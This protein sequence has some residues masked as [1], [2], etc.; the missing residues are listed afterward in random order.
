M[1]TELGTILRNLRGKIPLREAAMKI[2]ISHTYLRSLEKGEKDKPSLE[3]IKSLAKA[4]DYSE[5]E[6]MIKAG[7]LMSDLDAAVYNIIFAIQDVL[8]ESVEKNRYLQ[9]EID[10]F[11]KQ[12]IESLKNPTITVN[13]LKG[14][15]YDKE[16]DDELV[17]RLGDWEQ[18]EKIER[19]LN[20]LQK[21]KSDNFEIDIRKI[22][23]NALKEITTY[24]NQPEITYNGYQLT[25]QDKQLIKAYLDVL[26]QN[27]S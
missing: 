4:Y 22:S 7:H 21:V 24:L 11:R 13:S 19:L 20:L 25:D 16:P 27:R 2:G 6:L 26:F 8:K 1:N 10:D 12:L 15:L 3:T 18:T 17:P 14:H 5:K 23:G 9:K